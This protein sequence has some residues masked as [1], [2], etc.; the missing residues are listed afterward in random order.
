MSGF[1]KFTIAKPR[2]PASMPSTKRRATS[3]SGHLRLLVIRLHI[4]WRGNE[5]AGLARPRVFSSA[6]QE[7]RDVGVLL[8]LRDVQLANSGIGERLRERFLDQLLPERDR[9]IEVVVVPR[10]RRQVEAGVDELP[11][12]LARTVGAEVEEDRA[13]LRAEPGTALEYDG[14]DELV[15]D[16]VVVARLNG[17]D[18][19]DHDRPF[20]DD[21][22][23]RS[24]GSLP[25]SVA[26]H[27]VVAPANGRDALGG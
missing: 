15:R 16:A 24:L 20:G 2:P 26:V 27:R 5:L 18:G 17:G 12:Q 23:E 1:A 13:V 21:G 3:G 22:V 19:I 8:G 11:R 14:L 4:P 6:V 25:A 7:V 10:H 9:A